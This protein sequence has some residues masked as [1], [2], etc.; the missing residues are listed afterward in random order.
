MNTFNIIDLQV[1]FG[2]DQIVNLPTQ[3]GKILDL[4]VTNRPDMFNLQVGQ[5]LISTKHNA[6]IVN[7]KFVIKRTFQSAPRNCV[8]IR[9]YTPFSCGLLRQSP[10][11]GM[12]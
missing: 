7:V 10:A 6:L 1:Q 5:F 8:Q 3:G 11:I 4:F 2:F 12:D 9:D